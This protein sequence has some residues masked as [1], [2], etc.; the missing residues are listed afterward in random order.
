MDLDLGCVAS[1]L[2]LVDEHHFARAAVRLNL[3]SSALSKRIRRLEHQVGI[4]LVDRGPLGMLALTPAGIRFAREAGPLLAQ[5]SVARRAARND[6]GLYHV[7][8]GVP[9]ALGEYPTRAELAEIRNVLL[10]LVADVRLSCHGIP[11]QSLT[12]ALLDGQM[13]VVW[14]ASPV[15]HRS[16][17]SAPLVAVNRTGIVPAGHEWARPHPVRA[18]DFAEEPIVY[19]S[20]LPL[21]WMG[22]WYLGDIRPARD[23]R[24][25]DIRAEYSST[26]LASV[27]R[28]AGLATIPAPFAKHLG[29]GL[30]AVQLL[31]V[32]PIS[33]FAASRQRDRREPVL[34]L[35]QALRTVATL[36]V[37]RSEGIPF[38]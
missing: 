32:P 29:P 1:F 12:T 14:T 36:S 22:Q 9:G 37:A 3:S 4:E 21:A 8:L 17:D 20:S 16:I 11:F 24:L 6:P 38:P 35:I 23:A 33:F 19:D 18:E 30:A 27:A 7:R 15:Q 31:G 26:V 34:A 10:H 5:A 25:V 28:G 2:M 13:D